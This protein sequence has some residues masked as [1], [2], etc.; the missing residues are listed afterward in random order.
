MNEKIITAK[1][2]FIKKNWPTM[3]MATTKMAPKIG[4]SMSIK[5]SIY[6]YQVS[7][8]MIW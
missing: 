5:F 4:M 6:W 3:I 1:I 8:L 2:K 7:E